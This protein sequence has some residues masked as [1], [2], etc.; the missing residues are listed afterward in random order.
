M[1]KIKLIVTIMLISLLTSCNNQNSQKPTIKDTNTGIIDTNT[2]TSNKTKEQDV[3]KETLTYNWIDKTDLGLKVP[4]DFTISIFADKLSWA[5]D[6][7][8]PDIKWNYLLSRTSEWII[9]LLEN[10]N[11]VI[12]NKIDII[13]GLKNPHWLAL[14]PDGLTL[15]YAEGDKLSKL[16]LYS[17]SKPTKLIDLP[18]WWRHFTRSLLYGPDDKLYISI[19]S[20]CDTCI[21]QDERI[22][23]IYSVNTDWSNFEKVASWLRNSVFMAT[24]PIN[25]DLWATEMWRDN[26]WDDIPPDEINIIK[27]WNDYGWPICYGQNIH[28]SEF[29][30]KTYIRNPCLDKIPAHIDLQAHSAPLWLSFVPEEWWPENYWNDLLVSYHWSWNRSEPTWYKIVHIKLD[31][32]WKVEKIEDFIYG[33]LDEAG[34]GLGR[35]VDILTFPGWLAFVTDDKKG[36]VYKITY[37][38]ISVK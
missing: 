26:L 13:K 2:W 32:N 28:D 6:L 3:T 17:D 19:W 35:P 29:D 21:E 14:S 12:K 27:K 18:E 8:W 22:A 30:K 4:T 36:V 24:N 25:W 33:W 16:T 38:K 7:I 11:W 15:Y 1:I 34:S 23:T 37:D 20:T 31:D 10:S 9:T 5:R